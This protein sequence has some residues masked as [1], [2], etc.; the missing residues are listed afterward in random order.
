MAA[1]TDV[2][3]SDPLVFS[4]KF[5]KI[6]DSASA[7]YTAAS[8]LDALEQL[9]QFGQD[10]CLC[11]I[12]RQVIELVRIA[13]VIVQLAAELAA[14]P[15]GVTSTVDLALVY[16]WLYNGITYAMNPACSLI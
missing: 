11:A 3:R 9:L 7:T 2:R 15:F 4:N 10:F 8:V 5:E 16:I 12:P 6:L 14:V 13:V 1:A